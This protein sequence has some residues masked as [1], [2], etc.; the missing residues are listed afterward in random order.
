MAWLV[1][2]LLVAELLRN[3][4]KFTMADVLSFRLKQK[5]VR[6]AAATTTLV[7]CFFYLL[8][9]MA[10]AGGLVSLLL[11]IGDKVGQARRDH[12]RRRAHDPLRAHR[13][14][15]GHHVGADHQGGPAHRGRRVMTVWVLALNGFNFSTLLD[16]AVATAGNPAILDPGLQ[17]RRL[18]GRRS[19]TSSRSASRSCSAPRPCRTC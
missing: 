17:V 9:Q 13:R 4:G 2:L 12:G 16:N 6:I 11:G 1:A 15:E 10:G 19:S 14:H 5:P 18:R 7:V 8:A 3:T